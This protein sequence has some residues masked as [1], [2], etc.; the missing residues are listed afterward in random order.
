MPRRISSY[1]NTLFPIME[2]RVFDDEAVS[3]TNDNIILSFTSPPRERPLPSHFARAN[4]HEASGTQN[5][6]IND[7]SKNRRIDRFSPLL[8]V[9]LL[10]NHNSFDGVSSY[11]TERKILFFPT[12]MLGTVPFISFLAHF[13]VRLCDCLD[14]F[15]NG[16]KQNREKYGKRTIL[17]L[18]AMLGVRVLETHR[19][20]LLCD[21]IAYTTERKILFFGLLALGSLP[22]IMF[23]PHLV[24][25][26]TTHDDYD[27]QF[28]TNN[29]GCDL[30]NHESLP[31]R[32]SRLVA[33]RTKRTKTRRGRHSRKVAKKREECM[34]SPVSVCDF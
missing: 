33:S 25:Y 21:L 3:S 18:L 12:L 22:I 15:C 16:N 6:T 9:V 28:G 13:V 17:F 8:L 14:D 7:S 31:P 1:D 34:V 30:L 10:M 19:T 26:L 24:V 2:C 11:L 20:S 29:G 32:C 23:L 5:P 4:S 27:G